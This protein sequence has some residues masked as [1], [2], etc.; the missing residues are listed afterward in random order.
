[1]WLYEFCRNDGRWCLRVLRSCTHVCMP[2][3]RVADS[4]KC[5]PFDIAE[6]LIARGHASN[7]RATLDGRTLHWREYEELALSND[8]EDAETVA[9]MVFT[10]ES[11]VD[12]LTLTGFLRVLLGTRPQP[13]RGITEQRFTRPKSKK[14]VLSSW[15]YQTP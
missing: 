9:R 6:P 1:M 4:Q 15:E 7:F 2:V 12:P 14:L 10:I 8:D 5:T 3:W 13:K 11:S